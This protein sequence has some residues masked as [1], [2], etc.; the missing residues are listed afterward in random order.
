MLYIE[1]I[2]T[3]PEQKP[4][5]PVYPIIC[6][7]N[8]GWI[9]LALRLEN[10]QKFYV[11]SEESSSDKILHTWIMQLFSIIFALLTHTFLKWLQKVIPIDHL[12][13]NST[14]KFIF[15]CITDREL[16]EKLLKECIINFFFF[17]YQNQSKKYLKT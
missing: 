9:W 16:I 17:F 5:R 8:Q 12:D 1:R 2:S 3:E 15:R 10:D 7:Q 14:F 6:L 11:A 13:E 4:V